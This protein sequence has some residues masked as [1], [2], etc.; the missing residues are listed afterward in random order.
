MLKK[1]I[2]KKALSELL[3]G[4]D[5]ADMTESKEAGLRLSKMA[6]DH[7]LN[8]RQFLDLAVDFTAEDETKKLNEM[9]F[10]GYEMAKVK[11]G[12]P[13]KNDFGNQ[14]QLSNASNTFAMYAGA[15]SM[16]KYVIDDMLRWASRQDSM[17]T[18]DG[19][20]AGSRTI[21]G[22][23][24]VRQIIDLNGTD[25]AKTFDI[26]EM[27]NIPVRDV[28][29]SDY[30]V[31]FGK[32]G[33]GI[34][35]S[36]EFMRNSNIDVLTPFAARIARELQLQKI[37]R[38][39]TVMLN[40]DGHNPA[41]KVTKQ[42]ALDAS[43]NDGKL[44]FDALVK[45]IIEEAKRG[46]VVDRIAGNFD[47]YEQWIKMFTPNANV[48]NN[49]EN[50]A[51]RGLAPQFGTLSMFGPIQF[52]LDTSVPEGKLLC[53]NRAETIEELISEGSQL[54]E[55]QRFIL[56]QTVVYTKTEDVGYSLVYGDTRSVFD[57]GSKS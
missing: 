44:H 6:D 29:T 51:N 39:K 52:V 20:I 40:G 22:R 46:I 17:Q 19:L 49:P 47:A 56:N 43:A 21:Q 45:H 55:E 32:V 18:I 33:S 50:L 48:T 8:T 2:E 36:Y 37:D 54:E 57:F 15:R 42:V 9:G 5:S 53:F 3:K 23:E 31:K 10:S 14:I 12:L 13:T 1:K 34:R 27:G 28:R 7:G 38:C 16:F 25:T 26:A 11:L 30:S 4:I 35:L 24:Q 41:A